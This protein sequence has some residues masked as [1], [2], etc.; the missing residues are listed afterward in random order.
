MKGA[1]KHRLTTVGVPSQISQDR[2]GED[3]MKEA[4]VKLGPLVLGRCDAIYTR[5]LALHAGTQ[6]DLKAHDQ[7]L[8]TQ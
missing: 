6:I 5:M 2:Y 4:L 3:K 7:F 1:I 8:L